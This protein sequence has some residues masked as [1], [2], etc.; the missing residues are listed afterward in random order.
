LSRK[1]N[2]NNIDLRGFAEAVRGLGGAVQEC[3]PKF[4]RSVF[5][6]SERG[7]V[8][9]ANLRVAAGVGVV[10]AFFLVGAP[11]AALAGADTSGHGGHST[12]G[13]GSNGGKPGGSDFSD[14]NITFGPSK[15]S[16]G[17]GP[18]SRVGSGRDAGTSE[19]R[20][21][22]DYS[23]DPSGQPGQQF[24]PPRVTFGDGRTPGIQDHDPGPHWGWYAPEPAPPPPPPPPPP[25]VIAPTP[26]RPE[27]VQPR[28]IQQLVVA[29]TA[30]LH[31]PFFGLAGLLLIPAAGAILGYRQA[32]ASQDAD[33]LRQ[34]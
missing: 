28:G 23:P 30:A 16:S 8:G 33:K 17:E 1:I 2:A 27:H 4:I 12:N 14:D 24:K 10:A 26:P 22:N 20:P 19:E 15:S 6:A 32:R 13:K 7:V 11:S 29:P 25:P 3:C 18:Q 21:G 34:P 31:D 5:A 9:R